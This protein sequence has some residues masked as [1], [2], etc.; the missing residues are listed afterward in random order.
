MPGARGWDRMCVS[1]RKPEFW[2][3]ENILLLD[4]GN[5]LTGAWLHVFAETSNYVLGSRNNRSLLHRLFLTP[6]NRN[7]LLIP[8]HHVLSCIRVFHKCYFLCQ[9]CPALYLWMK[10]Y[11]PYV[12]SFQ[13]C[14][15]IQLSDLELS[16][17]EPYYYFYL[18][19]RPFS[20]SALG[21]QITITL[22]VLQWSW[23]TWEQGLLHLQE[24]TAQECVRE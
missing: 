10:L 4:C 6:V 16:C 21:A 13:W 9:E 5:S 14:Q 23:A 17:S 22:L 20:S 19:F 12:A 3:D 2:E 11:Q 18:S 1:E 7:H 15:F 8:K 24:H